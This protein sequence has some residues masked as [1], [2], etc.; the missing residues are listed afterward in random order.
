MLSIYSAAELAEF[1]TTAFSIR[2][3]THTPTIAV[4]VPIT[5]MQAARKTRDND[6]LRTDRSEISGLISR[7]TMN[8]NPCPHHRPWSELISVRFQNLDHVDPLI[9]QSRRRRTEGTRGLAGGTRSSLKTPYRRPAHRPKAVLGGATP[10]GE[11]YFVTPAEQWTGVQP[12]L[13]A[14][15]QIW[16][17]AL[18]RP[19]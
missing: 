1:W 5:T 8:D 16:E 2:F 18:S 7:S 11:Y 12:K 19:V 3:D 15:W 6:Q 10:T 4:A 13:F 17:C 14:Q 9:A